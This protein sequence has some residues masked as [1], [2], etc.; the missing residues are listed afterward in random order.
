M[1]RLMKKAD[2]YYERDNKET[3]EQKEIGYKQCA[4]LCCR[5]QNIETSTIEVSHFSSGM[6]VSFGDLGMDGPGYTVSI[7]SWPNDEI[8][9]IIVSCGKNKSGQSVYTETRDQGVLDMF[10]NG[11]N[12]FSYWVDEQMEKLES[13]FM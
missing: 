4:E 7:S 13:K 6:T 12:D 2:S 10:L 5:N 3:P 1:K 9:R 11:T 8:D